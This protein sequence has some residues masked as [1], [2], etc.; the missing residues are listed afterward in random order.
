[1]TR[2]EV[3]SKVISMIATAA[4]RS[5]ADVQEA[6]ELSDDL[7][8]D[9]LDAVELMMN[10]EKAFNITIDDEDVKSIYYVSDIIHYINKL[11]SREEISTK[12]MVAGT[13]AQPRIEVKNKFR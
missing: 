9:S 4:G 2:D 10:L 13:K 7:G 8:L 12:E 1:M 3:K 11:V 5:E 6:S